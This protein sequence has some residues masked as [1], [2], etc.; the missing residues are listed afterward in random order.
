M[1]TGLQRYN[2]ELLL[3]L[4][5][6]Q[7]KY[8]ALHNGAFVSKI[9]ENVLYQA[10]VRSIKATH[11]RAK[12]IN[13]DP[14]DYTTMAKVLSDDVV[15]LFPNITL[16]EMN[17]AMYNGVMR[18]YGDYFGLNN[19]NFIGWIRSFVNEEKRLEALSIASK[20]KKP[21]PE[22]SDE[23]KK[24]IA[25][26]SISTMVAHY[27]KTGEVLNHGNANFRYLWNTGQI[28]FGK[29]QADKYL[30]IAA[31]NITENLLLQEKE[32]KDNL[33]KLRLKSIS[34][35]I[36]GITTSSERVKIEA[37]RLA[38]IDYLKQK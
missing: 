10:C 35:Q 4:P 25:M 26:E 1:T 11:A 34:E 6:E 5:K 20:L 29:E 12:Q 37:G 19:V 24:A 27:K 31:E 23:K 2:N 32:A 28:K 33:D 14:D 9:D 30:A 3:T 17:E 16:M 21:K 18:V 38:I 15:R 8:V 7:Q 22:P 36:E 13:L